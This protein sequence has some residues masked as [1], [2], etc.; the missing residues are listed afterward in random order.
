MRQLGARLCEVQQTVGS[1]PFCLMTR[2]LDS[3]SFVP[4]SLLSWVAVSM[5]CREFLTM[6]KELYSSSMDF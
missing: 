3:E 2:A 5:H 1:L 4:R 6:K